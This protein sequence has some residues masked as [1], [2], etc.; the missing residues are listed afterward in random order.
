MSEECKDSI[1]MLVNSDSII[2]S[3]ENH[4][5]IGGLG[6]FISD[7]FNFNVIRIGLDRKFIT[8]YGSY[9]DLRKEAN[10]DKL[11]ILRAING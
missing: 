9:D 1:N 7:T 4:F 11:S 3:V 8:S 2:Y 10:M 6:D 5:K